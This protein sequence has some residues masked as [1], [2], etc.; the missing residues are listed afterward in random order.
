MS[1]PYLEFFVLP[2]NYY[3]TYPMVDIEDGPADT[4]RIGLRIYI[5]TRPIS[6]DEVKAIV[7][8]AKLQEAR[9]IGIY[10]PAEWLVGFHPQREL[11]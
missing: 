8:Y 1:K 2:R 10:G 6:D 11:L 7:V 4:K 9:H 5:L 3:A